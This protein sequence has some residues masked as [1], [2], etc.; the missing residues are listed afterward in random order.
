M[1]LRT[2]GTQVVCL[3]AIEAVQITVLIGGEVAKWLWPCFGILV[4]KLG[5]WSVGNV[6]GFVTRNTSLYSGEGLEHDQTVLVSNH[7]SA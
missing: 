4:L 2:P 3:I 1:H 6:S 7:K 5:Y